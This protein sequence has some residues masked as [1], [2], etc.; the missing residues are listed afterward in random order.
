MK[1]KK[2]KKIDYKDDVYNLRLENNHNYFANDICVSNCHSTGTKSVKDVL[3]KCKDSI[4]R[5]GLSGTARVSEDTAE[6]LTITS[7]LGPM[8]NKISANFLFKNNY[9][10]P[11]Y[12]RM[13]YL[14]Y[15]D[16]E[17]R[18][19]L[20]KLKAKKIEFDGSK[21][22]TLERQLIVEDEKRFNFIIKTISKVNKNS[23]VL[24]YNIKDKYGE[25]IFNKL[26]DVLDNNY[27]IFY[28]DGN[29][30]DVE[31]QRYIEKMD[32]KT[33]TTKILVASFGT[34]STGISILDLHYIFFVESFKSDRLI[35]QSLGRGMRLDVGKPIVNIIDFVDDFSY[36]GYKNYVLKHSEERED[37]YIEERFKYKKIRI[38]F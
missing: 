15:L 5:F 26:K 32:D 4:Y 3:S 27:E 29:T 23:M 9:A 21:M 7:L 24:F 11:L 16:Y 38:K 30:K 20:I 22:L 1:I 25:R 28:V 18:E 8:V 12:I 34:F 33:P 14:D 10:T 6:S 17:V 37:M 36:K 19:S 13:L 2:I 31:R 35:K